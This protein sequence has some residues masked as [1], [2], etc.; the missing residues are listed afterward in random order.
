VFLVG[1]HRAY[2]TL[3]IYPNPEY[4]QLDFP[5]SSLKEKQDH[6]RSLVASVNKFVAP[7]ERIVDF[8]I[9][10][11]D[12]DDEKGELTPKG[13]PRRKVVVDNFADTIEGLY[14]RVRLNVGGVDLTVPNWLFQSLGLT[15]QD[16]HA[17]ESEITLPSL[18]VALGLKRL[19]ETDVQV[20]SAI[21]RWTHKVLDL[22]DILATPR[23]WLGNEELVAFA[24]PESVARQA[25]GRTDVEVEWVG[26]ALPYSPTSTDHEMVSESIRHTEWAL[27]DL[28]RAA[29]MLSASD[30]AGAMNAVRLLERVLANEEGPLAEPARFLLSRGAEA[31]SPEVRKRVFQLLVPA[32]RVTRFRDALV[33]FF[34]ADPRVLDDETSE[35]LCERSLHEAKIEAL[36]DYAECTCMEHARDDDKDELAVSLLRFLADYGAVHPVRYRRTSGW[37]QRPRSRS[38]PKQARNTAGMT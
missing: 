9:I 10:D 36:I 24:H 25:T 33:R 21:Y 38:I 35:F 27:E 8:A 5:S 3:L 37:A 4:T 30:E 29:R 19:T 14:R 31:G 18:G 32:E 1:D 16:A 7:F 23:L 11:R 26:R 2:N 6:F 17:T 34:S 28:D 22:G 20:G 13:T 15:A 12:L